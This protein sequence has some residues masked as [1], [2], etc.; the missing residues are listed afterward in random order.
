MTRKERI[1]RASAEAIQAMH[2]RGESRSDWQTAAQ[3]SQAEVERLA[4]KDDGPL[5]QGWGKAAKIGVPE[6]TTECEPQ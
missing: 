3:L 2:D 1:V 5:P 6:L 4:E